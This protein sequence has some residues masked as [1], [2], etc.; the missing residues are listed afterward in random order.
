MHSIPKDYQKLSQNKASKLLNIPR[1]TF[2]RNYWDNGTL[3]I[4]QDTDGSDYVSFDELQ[5]VFG[6]KIVQAVAAELSEDSDKQNGHGQNSD[7]GQNGQVKNTSSSSIDVSPGDMNID[8]LLENE[9]LKAEK[10]GLTILLGELRE[11]L[12]R[13]RDRLEETESQ[14]KVLSSQNRALLVDK[15]HY[16]NQAK[17][18]KELQ[19]QQEALN[20]ELASSQDAQNRLN[21]ELVNSQKKSWLQK[22]FN[23]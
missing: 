9:R 13:E 18:I 16:E 7:I 12:T 5:R 10:E 14:V 6:E 15:K 8:V 20:K 23:L 1:T 2:R 3:S 19:T 4:K 21:E 11:Q 17:N 22:L